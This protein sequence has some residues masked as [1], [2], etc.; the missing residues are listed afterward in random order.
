LAQALGE[1]YTEP[2]MWRQRYTEPPCGE[3]HR[4][5]SW[6]EVD[7][8]PEVWVERC[9]ELRWDKPSLPHLAKQRA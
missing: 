7:T 5:P 3:G 9:T 2:E 1:G 8:E 6:G 4:K